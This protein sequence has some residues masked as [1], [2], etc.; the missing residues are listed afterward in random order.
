MT[1]NNY[2]IEKT[3]R[4][5][6]K[7]RNKYGGGMVSKPTMGG[8]IA[9][10]FIY[11]FMVITIFVCI[12]PIWHVVMSSI[13]EGKVLLAKSGLVVMPVGKINITGYKMVFSDS[14]ILKGYMNTII[15]V[16]GATIFGLILNVIA[17]YVLSRKS[18]LQKPLTILVL[19]TM[20]FSGGLIPTYM[21]IRSIGWVGTMWAILIPGCTHA[22]YMMIMVTAFR[23]VPSEIIEASM[24][25]GAKHLRIMLQIMLPQCVSM[26]T[27]V[28]LFSV[29]QQWNS[30]F[31]ASIYLSTKSELWPLQLWIKQIVAQNEDFLQVA[32]PN[33]DRYLIQYAVIVAATLPILC[34]F[35]IF[36]KY[37]EKG[38]LIGGVK[39]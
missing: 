20:M 27:V 7:R 22:V 15:Y 23:N 5:V 38:V 30:W 13:S 33:F 36:Q 25:D 29:V 4:P 37:I 19:I 32:N 21:V 14:S 2:S 6:I 17:G 12:I 26:M 28:I 39:G 16:C 34:L 10:V 24:I 1:S 3:N 11:L 9:N 18:M 35:P 31:P 8:I